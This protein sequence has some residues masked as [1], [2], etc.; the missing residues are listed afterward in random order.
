L[1]EGALSYRPNDDSGFDI[2]EE[3]SERTSKLNF[4]KIYYMT[5]LQIGL[6]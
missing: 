6:F 5:L 3:S 4:K 1:F 2:F